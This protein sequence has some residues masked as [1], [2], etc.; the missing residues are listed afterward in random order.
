MKLGAADFAFVGYFDLGNTRGVDWE[1]ALDT[2]T[3]GDFP[4]GKRCVNTAAALGDHEA[5][6]DLDTLFAA[7]NN[8][9]MHLDGV[10]YVEWCNVFLELLL[11][12]FL[13]D[14]HDGCGWGKAFV[15]VLRQCYESAR[16]DG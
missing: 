16:R 10:A 1:H 13:D 3:V 5:C 12:D 8:P 9:A 15:G 11:L 2:F 6:E 14:V 7:L 4:N